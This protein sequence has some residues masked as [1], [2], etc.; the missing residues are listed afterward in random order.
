MY[1]HAHPCTPIAGGLPTRVVLALVCCGGVMTMYSLRITLSVA[2]VEM[3]DTV[4]SG[5]AQAVVIQPYCLREAAEVGRKL[6]TDS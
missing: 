6:E 2:I 3:Y 4:D 5:G 1:T